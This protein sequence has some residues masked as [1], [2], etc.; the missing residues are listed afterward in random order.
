MYIHALKHTVYYI[1]ASELHAV[2]RACG[3]CPEPTSERARVAGLRQR[4]DSLAVVGSLSPSLSLTPSLLSRV[5]ARAAACVG[6][7][8][9]RLRVKREREQGA[10]RLPL[11]ARES[12]GEMRRCCTRRLVRTR[13]RDEVDERCGGGRDEMLWQVF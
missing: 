4:R 13:P 9:R 12:V 2:A 3:D 11:R 7:H 5:E 8:T 6:V 10:R 1:S